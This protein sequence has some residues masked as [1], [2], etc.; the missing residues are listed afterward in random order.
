MALVQIPVAAAD[1][2]TLISTLTL[3]GVSPTIS[4]IPGT[5]K[6]LYGVVYGVT[7][8]INGAVEFYPNGGSTAFA[9]TRSQGGTSS[10]FGSGSGSVAL[11]GGISSLAASSSNVWTFTIDNYASTTRHPVSWSGGFT[12]S[13][14]TICSVNGGGAHNETSAVT[15]IAFNTSGTYSTGTCLLYGVK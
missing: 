8:S 10:T 2:I 13:D 5:Y 3:S 11:S 12:N 15:S 6:S 4:S 14:S 7:L 9:V 1:S